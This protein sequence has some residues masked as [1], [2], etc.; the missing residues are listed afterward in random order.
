M[1]WLDEI[2]YIFLCATAILMAMLPFQPEPHLVEKY[3][4]LM[5]GHLHRPIDLFDIFWHLL[6]TFLLI[7]KWQR[8]LKAANKEF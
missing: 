1:K 8:S 6:P 7:W 3:H 5:E 4:L 2:P